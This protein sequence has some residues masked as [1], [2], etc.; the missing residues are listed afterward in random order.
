[1]RNRAALTVIDAQEIMTACKTESKKTNLSVSIA[2]I[3]DGGSL[4]LLERGDGIPPAT[5]EAAIG[6][7]RIAVVTQ[8]PSRRVR[9]MIKDDPAMMK[10]PGLPLPGGIPLKYRGE[11]VGGIGISGATPEDDERIAN[12]GAAA[13]K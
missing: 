9:E 11:C 5:A 1:M 4:I 8:L 2:I 13:L 12:A 6:K 10:L 7:A 3:D